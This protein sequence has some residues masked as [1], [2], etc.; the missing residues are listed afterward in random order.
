MSAGT[1]PRAPADDRSVNL[2]AKDRT[3]RGCIPTYYHMRLRPHTLP[4]KA[5]SPHTLPHE[6]ASPHIT[7]RGSVPTHYHT[8]LRPHT[9]PHEALSHHITTRGFVLTHYHTRLCPHTL[10]QVALSPHITTQGYVPTH[11]HTK[12]CP[13][14]LPHE[15]PQQEEAK[16]DIKN[17]QLIH[18]VQERVPLWD[19]NDR[20]HSD[21][22]VIRQLWEEVARSLL[23]DWDFATPR[24]RND[25]VK[26]IRVL[27]LDEGSF[28][29]GHE[30]EEPEPGA[31][32]HNLDRTL[33]ERTLID[34]P[35]NRQNPNHPPAIAGSVG[36]P[37]TSIPDQHHAGLPGC[38][39][40]CIAAAVP[41]LQSTGQRILPAAEHLLSNSHSTELSITTTASSSSQI[42]YTP[43]FIIPAASSIHHAPKFS[44]LA[45]GS[46]NHYFHKF[47]IPATS[48]IHHAA[49]S[50][51]TPEDFYRSHHSHSAKK[52]KGPKLKIFPPG[53]RLGVKKP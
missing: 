36:K 44:T 5:A 16:Q 53:R 4:H 22:A 15:V 9:L 31:A 35:T 27:E 7:T 25:F 1:D 24:T 51:T 6:A 41:K 43:D 28:Q 33:L 29:Q 30:T 13:P 8:R 46:I 49:Q 40:P 19:I 10:P 47:S 17:R 12:L 20:Q 34:Q 23:H 37:Y 39:Q 42:H 2:L 3:R 38:L 50:I 26:R 18:L 52:A 21:I 32:P 48:S 14:T 11:Y 45:A